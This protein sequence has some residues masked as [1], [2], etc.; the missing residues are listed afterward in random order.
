MLD[1]RT[2]RMTVG[3]C[4]T[5]L[6]LSDLVAALFTAAVLFFLGGVVTPQPVALFFVGLDLTPQPVV[7]F[8]VMMIVLYF[9]TTTHPR[10]ERLA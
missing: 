2:L 5:T 4:A 3:G 9:D 7:L 1:T 8:L 6:L 10:T